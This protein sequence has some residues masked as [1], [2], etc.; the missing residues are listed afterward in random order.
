MA[1]SVIRP[2]A[3]ARSTLGSGRQTTTKARASAPPMTAVPRSDSP[4]RGASPRRSARVAR[5]GGPIS[6][7]S[8]IV[9][10]LPETAS[11][12]VRSVARKASSRSG[13]TR[14]VSPTTRPGSRARA[15]GRSPSVASRSPARR[16][17]ASRCRGDGALT[18]TGGASAVT[19]STAATWSAGESGGTACATTRMRVDGSSPRHA[20]DKLSRAPGPCAPSPPPRCCTTTSTGVRTV[21]I[22]PP[23]AVTRTASAV[24]TSSG[25][26]RWEPRT[27]G[28]VSRGSPRT[29][30]SA[31]SPA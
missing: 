2:Q 10:L 19:R 8:T 25:G 30:S 26:V 9:R 31:V 5:C 4:R 15:S 18:L 24:N 17:P 28:R 16:C 29:S 1:R 3:A 20:D 14:E 12:W 13:G 7:A 27:L 11:K 21:V 6:R 22:S 23:G